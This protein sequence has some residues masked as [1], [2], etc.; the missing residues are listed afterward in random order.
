M[1][2]S[3]ITSALLLWA[4]TVSAKK[5]SYGDKPQII[6]HTG[7][8]VGSEI[9]VN[10]STLYVSN[11]TCNKPKVGVLYLTDAFSIQFVN[12]KLLA[13]SFARAGF[14][15][16]APDMFN[17]DP[18]PFD[19]AT[20]GF[21]AT[22]WT[23]RH[24]PTAI[25]PILAT[26]V[27][28][29]RSR[30]VTKVAAAGYCFGGRYSFRMLAAGLGVDVGFSAHPSLLEDSEILAVTGPISI[31][32]AEVD[33]MMPPARRSAIEGLLATSVAQPYQVNLYGGTA[34]GFGT[35][36]NISD[37]EQKFGKE[38]AFYQAVRWFDAWA[39]GAL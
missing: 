21:N 35:R 31:A 13:D 9:V 37:P 10:G 34:H 14:L 22:E 36:G 5:C 8:P 25:H 20:P 18:A 24:N 16:V 38:A 19:L 27:A 15:T 39:G 1:R 33:A 23:L 28:Y 2:T 11:T 7:T 30:G 32:A 29:L 4:G 3:F 17:N 12:N 26:A 6:A